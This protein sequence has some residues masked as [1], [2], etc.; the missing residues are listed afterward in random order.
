MGAES[1]ASAS[2]IIDFGQITELWAPFSH[3]QNYKSRAIFTL[4]SSK[5]GFGGCK[6]MYG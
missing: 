3:L 6:F 2:L 5:M 1:K 4:L